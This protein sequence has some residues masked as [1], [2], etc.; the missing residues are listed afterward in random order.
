MVVLNKQINEGRDIMKPLITVITCV[1]KLVDTVEKTPMT[2]ASTPQTGRKNTEQSRSDNFRRKTVVQ[3]RRERGR[4][5]GDAYGRKIL[6]MP[7]KETLQNISELVEDGDPRQI[8]NDLKPIGEGAVGMVFLASDSRDGSMVALKKLKISRKSEKLL[9]GEISMMKKNHHPAIVNYISAYRENDTLWVVM[10]YMA[11]GT[12]TDVLE[13][14]P[15]A[16]I[17]E[18]VTSF[19]CQQVLLGLEYIHTKHRIH[20]DIKSDNILLGTD[21]TVKLADFGYAAQLTQEQSKRQTFVGTPNWMAPE[22]MRG[23]KYDGKVDIWS[24]GITLIEI[25]E[26]KPPYMSL[27]PMRVIYLISTK[28][29]PP[30]LVRACFVVFYCPDTK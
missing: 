28:G 7:V 23:D 21:G 30:L 16:S 6:P 26:G 14:V 12:L 17:P 1:R 24:T 18:T 2:F 4:T 22:V 13:V 19:V 8:F 25:I 11:A 20:R 15:V 9:A 3:L 5:V 29:I 10:E 27:P